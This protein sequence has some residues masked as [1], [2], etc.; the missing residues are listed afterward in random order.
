MVKKNTLLICS[1]AFFSL[2]GCK[3]K[4]ELTV[5]VNLRTEYLRE[6][7]GL[8]TKSPRFTWEYKGSEKN[9]LASRSEIRIGTSP[10]NLQPYT[11]NMTLEPHTR[12]YW[13]V[14][15]W[16]QD[17]D[18]CETSETATFET[19]KFKS[20]DWSGKWI[21]DSHDKEFEPAPMF[22]KAFTLGKEIEEARVYVAAAGYYDLFINGKRVGENYLDP[23]YTHFDKRILYVTHDV[24]SLLK[25]GGNAIATVLGNGWYNPKLSGISRLPVGVT[26]PGCSVNCAYAIPMVRLKSS[27]PMKV[28]IPRPVPIPITTSTAVTNTMPRWKKMV[29]TRKGSMTASGIR[30]KLRKLRLPYWP[31]SRCR[32]SGLRKNCS[33]SR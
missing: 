25:P 8:D 15:V 18:I 14:T 27:P 33:L 32:V 23:G 10:D 5:P 21:T 20:S 28:G 4:N 7:I 31:P 19:A 1:L 22:R 12:Y 2:M 16:D 11:D 13:N 29:G 9:F 6:P 26:V 3:G 30:Y 17:G 24:T